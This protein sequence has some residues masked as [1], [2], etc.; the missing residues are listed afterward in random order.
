MKN[1]TVNTIKYIWQN[2]E[3]DDGTDATSNRRCAMLGVY[4]WMHWRPPMSIF[5]RGPCWS[6]PCLDH[7][8]GQTCC[9]VL[10]RMHTGVLLSHETVLSAQRHLARPVS[11]YW[12]INV[13]VE[14][15]ESCGH[16][17]WDRPKHGVLS[18][19][20]KWMAYDCTGYENHNIY[21]LSKTKQ[22]KWIREPDRIKY[23]SDAR[24]DST[25]Q[26]NN[27]LGWYATHNNCVPMDTVYYSG[28]KRE[29]RSSIN[30]KTKPSLHV[31]PKW[32]ILDALSVSYTHLTLPT[33]A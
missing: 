14:S 20:T 4:P 9:H 7:L 25:K 27:A 16:G 13:L 1:N 2:L 19:E 18:E 29:N 5:R 26:K 3:A 17:L 6:M 24:R 31:R 23:F 8:A 32:H 10:L 30:T 22:S 33:K 11:Q 15:W 28:R 12:F 21:I